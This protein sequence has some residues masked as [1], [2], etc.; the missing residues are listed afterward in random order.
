MSSREKQ[1]IAVVGPSK[2]QSHLFERAVLWHPR[3]DR[4]ACIT[5]SLLR[6]AIYLDTGSKLDGARIF[7]I[8]QRPAPR[9]GGSGEMFMRFA[10]AAYS[11]SSGGQL[12]NA[13]ENVP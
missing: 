5:K 2:R 1:I 13:C 10:K 4:I 11:S 6:S 12:E 8:L 9:V 3:F 7:A